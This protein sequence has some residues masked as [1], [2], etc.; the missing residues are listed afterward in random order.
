[1]LLLPVVPVLLVPVVQI[2]VI[3]LLNCYFNWKPDF[4]DQLHIGFEYTTL[5]A[6]PNL[7]DVTDDFF[8]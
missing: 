5:H 2:K 6:F 7:P 4:L 8:K 1:M 3:F